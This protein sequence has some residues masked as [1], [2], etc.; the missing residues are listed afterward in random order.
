[1][2]R[3]IHFEIAAKDPEVITKFYREALGW[4][5]KAWE[6]G[7][8][9]WLVMTGPQG[10]PGIDG[11]IMP[12]GFSQPVINTVVVES[13]DEAQARIEAAGGKKV[14]GPNDIPGVGRHAYFAD[15]EGTWF[16]V[17]QPSEEMRM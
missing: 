17:L 10:T 13:L 7:E 9:Y 11:G 3:V 6:G 5:I 1:M 12:A 8:G 16:G 15:P 2:D 4:E 14:Y